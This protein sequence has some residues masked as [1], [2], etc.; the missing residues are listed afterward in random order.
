MTLIIRNDFACKTFR[1]LTWF[2]N[3]R[4]AAA[5]AAEQQL[6]LIYLKSPRPTG[7]AHPNKGPRREE[8]KK[9]TTIMEW[10][11]NIY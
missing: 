4:A 3:Y 1:N 10:S 2:V 6:F 11:E 7:A 9:Q 5:A 8:E